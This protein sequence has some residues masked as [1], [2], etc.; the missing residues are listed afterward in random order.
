LYVL[1]TFYTSKSA[2]AKREGSAFNAAPTKYPPALRPSAA[3][4]WKRELG[5]GS[6][7]VVVGNPPAFETLPADFPTKNRATSKKS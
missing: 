4:T 2:A 7:V 5:G 6:L 1:G 3:T